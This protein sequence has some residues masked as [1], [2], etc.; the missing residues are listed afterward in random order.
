[1][2][3]ALERLATG[4]RSECTRINQD[5]DIAKSQLRDYEARLGRP[6]PHEA[7]LAELTTLRDILRIGLSGKPPE[8]RREELPTVSE[9]AERIKALQAAN[10]IE[11]SPGRSAVRSSFAEEPVT[12]KIRRRTELVP[13]PD[14]DPAVSA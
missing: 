4:Y 1:V 5:L 12:S 11:A 14:L 3:N 10:T 6:F 9:L 2:L 7:Y 8:E 13:A